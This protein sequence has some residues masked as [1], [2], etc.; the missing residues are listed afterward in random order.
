VVII[1]IKAYNSDTIEMITG[2]QI[3]NTIH[4]CIFMYTLQVYYFFMPQQRSRKLSKSPV[5]KT[6]E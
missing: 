4:N 2:M 1:W 3:S 6:V 5:R